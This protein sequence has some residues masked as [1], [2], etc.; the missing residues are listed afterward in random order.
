ME[1]L[2]L[3]NALKVDVDEIEDEDFSDYKETSAQQ[4]INYSCDEPTEQTTPAVSEDLPSVH[5]VQCSISPY[6]YAFYKHHP[7]KL[8]IDTGATSSL[9]SKSFLQSTGIKAKPTRHAARQVDRSS[10]V[11]Q[12][13]IHITLSYGNLQLPIDALVVDSM[14]CDI[15]VGVPFCKEND[16]TV[17]L[18]QDQISIQGIRIPYGAKPSIQHDIYRTESYLLRN[19]SSKVLFPGEFLEIQSDN[20]VGYNSEI[21]IEPRIDSPLEG[22]WPAP[23]VSRV[24]D[25]TIR[26]PNLSNKP[27]K[28]SKSQHIAQIRQVQTPN[29]ISTVPCK[30]PETIQ[31]TSLKDHIFSSLI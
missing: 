9:V 4:Q 23:S 16:I 28:L 20:L 19:N 11:I 14:D 31:S 15:L 8:L 21:A 17:H 24:I 10:I 7:C 27:I 22:N 30:T 3:V 26:I 6:F 2:E 18:K 29:L 13:E 12:G 1:K 25:S 5:R